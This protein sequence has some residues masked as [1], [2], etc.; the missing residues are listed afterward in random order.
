M[1]K[2]SK[3]NLHIDEYP[4]EYRVSKRYIPRIICYYFEAPLKVESSE[5]NGKRRKLLS[6][7]F[8]VINR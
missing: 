8:R 4:V 1:Q 6:R 3:S 5:D 2:K 7:V